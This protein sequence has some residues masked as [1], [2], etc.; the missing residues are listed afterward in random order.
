MMDK[1]RPAES[2]LHRR[3]PTETGYPT[4]SSNILVAGG[5][6]GLPS[7][8][9]YFD[10]NLIVL[11]FLLGFCL[12]YVLVLAIDTWSGTDRTTTNEESDWT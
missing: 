4:G 10:P 3:C 9:I 11:L 6:G 2:I 7:G 1:Q 12:L 5:I 8:I